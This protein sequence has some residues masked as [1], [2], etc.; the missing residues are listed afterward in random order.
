V[1]RHAPVIKGEKTMNIIHVDGTNNK[2]SVFLYALSTCP[3]C[4][5]TKNFL[6]EMK[7]KYDYLDVDLVA[8][9]EQEKVLEELMAYNENGGFPTV[10]IDKQKVIIGYQPEAI[11]AALQ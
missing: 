1:A 4:K 6:N 10:I 9:D 2:K 11:K 7:I 8:P 5:K 3:W